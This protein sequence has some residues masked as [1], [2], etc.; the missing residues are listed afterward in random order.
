MKIL[1][2]LFIISGILG[3]FFSLVGTI[4]LGT[5]SLEDSEDWVLEKKNDR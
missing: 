1:A 5:F 4:N 2:W 3:D